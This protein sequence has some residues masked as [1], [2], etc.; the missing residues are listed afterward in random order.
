M[1]AKKKGLKRRDI[2]YHPFA[3]LR[4]IGLSNTKQIDNTELTDT[5]G[6]KDD[7]NVPLFGSPGRNIFVRP[8][9]FLVS[10]AIVWISSQLETWASYGAFYEGMCLNALRSILNNAG[11][12]LWFSLQQPMRPDQRGSHSAGSRAHH[13]EEPPPQTG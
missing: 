8:G 13:P 5:S 2:I 10:L 12:L 6:G 4:R 11:T 1:L 3:Q 9:F 7:L